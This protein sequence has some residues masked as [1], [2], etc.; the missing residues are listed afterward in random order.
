[1]IKYPKK[2]NEN[3]IM[4]IVAVSD[5]ANEDK[6]DISI[7]NFNKLGFNVVETESVRCSNLLVSTDGKTRAEEFI[8]LWQNRNVKYILSARGGEFLMEMLPYLDEYSNMIRISEPK[9]VQGYSDPSLLLFYLT[10]KFEIA[11]IH[12]ENLSEFAMDL[13]RYHKC[14][15]N[16][17]NFLKSKDNEFVE[18][19]FDKYQLTEFE[20]GNFRGYNLTEDSKCVLFGSND[21]NISVEGRIIGG[22]IDA[23]SILLGTKYDYANKFCKKYDEGIIWYIDNCELNSAEFYRRLWQAREAGWFSNVN[24]FLIGRSYA[25]TKSVGDF[26]FLDAINKAL[27]DLNVPIIYNVDIGHVPPQ[28]TIINGSYAKVEYNDGKLKLTQKLC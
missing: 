3:D 8:E 23:L 5:G 20:E 17:I 27:Y 1:M 24:A 9:W 2:L 7:S 15:K 11:T 12:A 21:K 25:F 26:T 22:C 16:T 14:L 19:S 10:T 18:E 6:I 13:D 28:L 4:G